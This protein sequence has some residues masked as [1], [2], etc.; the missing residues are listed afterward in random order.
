MAQIDQFR[1]IVDEQA[2]TEIDGVLV[3]LFSASAVVQ[4]HDA[5]SADNA[6]KFAALPIPDIADVA[7]KLIRKADGR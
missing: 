2:A 7:F 3:D 6:A 5:L 4:V 1:K